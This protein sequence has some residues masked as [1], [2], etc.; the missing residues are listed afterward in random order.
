[1]KDDARLRFAGEHSV[2]HD[3]VV[4]ERKGADTGSPFKVP[5]M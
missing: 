2:E 1:V 5:R 4:G 3:D